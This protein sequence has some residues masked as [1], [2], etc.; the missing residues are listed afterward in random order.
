MIRQKRPRVGGPGRGRGQRGRA[1]SSGNS[2]P[3]FELGIKPRGADLCGMLAETRGLYDAAV[4][5]GD[6]SGAARHRR[7]YELLF[8]RHRRILLAQA[9]RLAGG[10]R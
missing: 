1:S 2:I 4:R 5:S 3:Y 8:E 9:V 7:R 10:A 6:W